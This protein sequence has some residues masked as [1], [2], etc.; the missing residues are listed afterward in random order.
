MY[1]F[2]F[3]IQLQDTEGHGILKTDNQLQEKRAVLRKDVQ[4]MKKWMRTLAA[5]CMLVLVL[6]T[7][8]VAVEA[9]Q[10]PAE[11]QP[12]LG[13]WQLYTGARGT[14][15]TYL[16]RMQPGKGTLLR[17]YCKVSERSEPTQAKEKSFR[18]CLRGWI[19]A[20]KGRSFMM[21]AATVSFA[22]IIF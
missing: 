4:Q 21:W 18:P 1:N 12:S 17:W 9:E 19:R 2:C 11:T 14:D 5:G 10:P 8:A 13:A 6:C 3:K 22:N 16:F 15:K 7:F 20:K